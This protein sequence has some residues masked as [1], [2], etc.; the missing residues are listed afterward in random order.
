MA[1][2]PLTPMEWQ[3]E[4]E[5]GLEYRHIFG[6]EAFWDVLEA[7]Y[8]NDPH[9]F[10][11]IGPNLIYSMGDSLL[12]AL[13]VPDPEV[14]VKPLS[15]QS[16]QSSPIVEAQSNQFIKTLGIKQ[17]VEMALLHTYL[18]GRGILKIGYDS[19]FGFDHRH[20]IGGDQPAGITMT[21]FDGKGN[22]IESG[23][24]KPGQPWVRAVSPHD[25]VV[26]WGTKDLE[27][28]PWV[29][30]RVVRNNREVKD[31]PKYKNT[32]NLQPQISMEQFMSSY[33]RGAGNKRLGTH[34]LRTFRSNSKQVFNELWE[35][36]DRLTGRVYVISPDYMEFLRDDIDAIQTIGTQFV[37]V[38]FVRHPRTFWVTPQS[39]YLL[40]IQEIEFDI[41]KQAEKQRRINVLRFITDST[42]LSDDEI[43]KLVSG[44]V[45]AVARAKTQKPLKEVI[46]PVPQGSNLD[47]MAHAEFIRKDAR[48]AVGM[49]RNQLGEFDKGTRR[50]A[51]EA[52]IVQQGSQNRQSRRI[53][54]MIT[55][56]LGTVHK[57]IG[58]VRRFWTLPHTVQVNDN[59]IFF[60]GDDLIGEFNYDISL[61]TKR[62]MSMTDRKME[63]LGLLAN[64]AQYPG[65]NLPA[66]EE[67]VVRVA[68]DPTFANFFL[69]TSGKK[70]AGQAGS[71]INQG[72][73]NQSS[74]PAGV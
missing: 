37:S 38:S 48:D 24:A 67:Q 11:A 51:K 73:A 41:H 57:L 31:D 71:S 45:G 63:A 27:T 50:T 62:H 17:E 72:N 20:D 32:A 34:S 40:P 53:D 14:L 66:I 59:W 46:V 30:H 44:D 35:I 23:L 74:R 28:A 4:I 56:Y 36:H 3:I 13:S 5:N 65:A 19:E 21:Q 54:A 43:N 49:S 52:S 58:I 26:P 1:K 12:S 2:S 61:S 18:Y 33:N 69:S 42:S 22:R 9:S 70:G 55:L 6:R 10:A 39:Y 8:L 47:L 60:T 15:A 68:N 64:M 29:A 25:I 7:T 16:V